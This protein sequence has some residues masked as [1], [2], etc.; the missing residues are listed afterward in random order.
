MRVGTVR[1][2][3]NRLRPLTP[4]WVE[5]AAREAD[6]L[7]AEIDTGFSGFLTLP[8]RDIERLQLN[9]KR[10]SEVVMADGPSKRVDVYDAEIVWW[11]PS[12]E[13]EVH[14]LETDRL[15]GISL[16]TGSTLKIDVRTGGS[17][18]IEPSVP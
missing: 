17:V 7:I 5:G 15:I 1:L 14:E 8:R 3:G 10:H 18:E 2:V 6:V 4:V 11:G 16:L 12:Q 9:F 13:I